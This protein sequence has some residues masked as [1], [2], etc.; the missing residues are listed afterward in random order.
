MAKFIVLY[1]APAAVMSEWMQTPLEQREAE[2]AKMREDWNAWMTEHGSAITETAGAG[3][4][5]RV[6]ASGITDVSNDVM[7]YSIVEAPSHDEVAAMFAN[8]PHL[9][10]PQ[11]TIEV[12]T[13]NVLPGM[14]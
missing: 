6:A 2:E 13:A 10:I 1:L 14:G 8:H 3:K 12:M 9:Q 5:K 11:A 7:L 4:T